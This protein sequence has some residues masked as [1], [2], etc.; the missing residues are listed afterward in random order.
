MKKAFLFL[1]AVIITASSFAQSSTA[2]V[3]Y[4]KIN[5]QAVVNDIPFPEKTV[6]DAI[7]NKMQQM[8]Y[9]GKDSKAFTIYKGVKM[10]ALGN[11]A[12]DIY[13]SVDR[14]SKK[15]KDMAVVTM[16]LS[17][18]FDSFI[19]DSTDATVINNA[20]IYLN[21]LREMV[22]AYDLEMQINDQAEVIKKA[23]K[24]LAN[25]KQDGEDMEKKKKKLE[26]D[27]EQ[28]KK[29]VEAQNAEIEKQKQIFETL[30]GKR[31]SG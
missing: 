1:S 2:T 11:D 24:K 20:K 23:D 14:K 9:K 30:K 3:E 22:A 18:G 16:L 27:I 6:R 17:K 29:D 19:A 26:N 5:R 8:G 25:L 28:N 13:F 21:N 15:E 4:Q 31:K 12:Y 10:A 7:D